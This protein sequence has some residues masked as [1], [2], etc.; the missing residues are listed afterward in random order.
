LPGVD[1]EQSALVEIRGV[2]LDIEGKTF[3]LKFLELDPELQRHIED[4]ISYAGM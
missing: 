1:G 3:G 4:F 2:K